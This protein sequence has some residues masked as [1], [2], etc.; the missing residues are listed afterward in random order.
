MLPSLTQWKERDTHVGL[1][2]HFGGLGQKKIFQ[3]M[4]RFV[5]FVMPA[6]RDLAAR[7]GEGVNET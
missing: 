2:V 6:S 3:S 7:K 5:R 4:E 1:T